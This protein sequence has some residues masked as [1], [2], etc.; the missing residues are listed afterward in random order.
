M[1]YTHKAL[2]TLLAIFNLCQA[3]VA[4]GV[5]EKYKQNN[6]FVCVGIYSC[7]N[8][9]RAFNANYRT[10]HGIESDE[11]LVE[12]ARTI[13]P[14]D[15]NENRFRITDYHIHHG[16]LEAFEQLI[17]PIN[18]PMTIFLGNHC[19]EYDKLVYNNIL[20]QL[21]VIK[22]HSFNNHVICIDY[23]QHEGTPAF[24]N[25]KLEQILTKLYEINPHYKF[26]FEQGGVVE[27][28]KNAVLI[29]YL[30]K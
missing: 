8:L 1:K 21:D 6:I 24:G 10:V 2:C 27:S 16:N 12:H 9:A 19:P 11:V 20:E 18:A 29:A 5:L 23:I 3:D 30:P 13:F 28:E 14:H 17:A 22:R 15:M 25:I 4:G 7:V 26:A